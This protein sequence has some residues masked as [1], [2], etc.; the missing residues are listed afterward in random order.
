M[1]ARRTTDRTPPE[2]ERSPSRQSELE[3]QADR[4]VAL[5]IQYGDVQTI[6]VWPNTGRGHNLPVFIAMFLSAILIKLNVVI[7]RTMGY[8]LVAKFSVLSKR[9]HGDYFLRILI[10]AVGNVSEK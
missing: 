2:R 9:K 7:Y 10:F 6:F 1:N 8:F 4:C 3:T 5:Y